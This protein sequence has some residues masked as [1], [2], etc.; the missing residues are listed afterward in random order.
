VGKRKQRPRRRL[1]EHLS[2]VR[3]DIADP[4][5]E[6]A[7]GRILV[8]RSIVTNPASMVA[9]DA[10]VVAVQPVALRG[11]TKLR[12]ALSAFGDVRVAGR[13]ALDAGA[14]AGGFTRVLLAAGARRVYAVD[15]GHGQ[16]LGSLRQ[17]VRV[18]NLEATNLG[19]LDRRLV[20]DV[21]ELVT[22]DLSYVSLA[23]AAG[24]LGRIALARDA[25][26][27]ALVK[28]MFELRLA[29]A[30]ADPASLAEA[31]ARA[32]RGIEAAG[33]DVVAHV[34]S[35]VRGARG[36]VELLLRARRRPT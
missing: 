33:W 27:V 17:D 11:E 6:I 22:L 8:D 19:D 23:A 29:R 35:S 25:D 18:V 32:A 1:V 15:A 16:L 7:A 20:P 5:A 13:V 21:V 30:P 36:A 28:P 26:L 9:R 24:Q 14:A 31:L 2:V 4:A 34:D 10:S 3:P 12:G